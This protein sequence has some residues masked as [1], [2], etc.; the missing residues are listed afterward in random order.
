MKT[1]LALAAAFFAAAG[2]IGA[3][4]GSEYAVA[5]K[6]P[7]GGSGHWDYIVDDAAQH[8]LYM[9]HNVRVEVVDSASRRSLG[10]VVTGGFTHG[11]AIVHDANRGYITVGES[12]VSTSPPA[13]EVV[14]FDL[15]TLAIVQRIDVEKDPDGIIYDPASKSV[16]AFNGDPH[17][18][19]VIDGATGHVKKTIDL[20]GSPEGSVVDG[21]GHLFVNISDTNQIAKIDTATLT[22]AKKWMLP[23][24]DGPSGLAMNAATHRLYSACDN[25][26][27]VVVNADTGAAVTTAPVAPKNDGIAYDPTSHTIFVSTLRGA[28]SILRDDGSDRIVPMQTLQT[29]LGSRTLALDASTHDVYLSSA[30]FQ[31]LKE[32]QKYPTPVVGTFGAVIVSASG[33]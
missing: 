26:L 6:I 21:H 23:G 8:R 30:A 32:G 14:A 3:A 11:I 1:T 16:F 13:H 33:S 25:K 19:T 10:G 27:L 12:S 7:V 2:P 18:V 4:S 20:G 31:P 17:L 29:P 5:G 9:S 28:L 22:V 15:R 24:C